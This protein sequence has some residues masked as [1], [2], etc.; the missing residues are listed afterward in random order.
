MSKI[1]FN[2]VVIIDIGERNFKAGPIDV[3]NLLE[4]KGIVTTRPA[5]SNQPLILEFE[6]DKVKK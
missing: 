5:D 1:S 2:A 6:I 3:R 4:Q